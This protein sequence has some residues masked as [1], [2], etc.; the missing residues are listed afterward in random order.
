MTARD[1][2]ERLMAE[3][4]PTG[5]FG[6]ARLT[7]PRQSEP[8]PAWTPQEQARHRAELL[9]ALDG[10]EL[11][12]EQAE[13]KRDRYREQRTHLRLIPTPGNPNSHTTHRPQ[14][15]NAA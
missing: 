9:A 13:R 3:A 8:S 4:M 2:Y 7:Q 10:F 1:A 12:D 5:T 15:G 14:E 11:H 6:R